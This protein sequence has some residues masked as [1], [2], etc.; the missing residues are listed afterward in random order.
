MERS[1]FQTQVVEASK[2]RTGLD[3]ATE[4]ELK[5]E[6]DLELA[7]E[8]NL[9]VWN[10]REEYRWVLMCFCLCHRHPNPHRQV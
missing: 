9:M 2:V 3:P 4:P 5:S 7:R 10:K 8:P 1:S 6:S